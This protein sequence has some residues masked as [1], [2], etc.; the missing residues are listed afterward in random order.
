MYRAQSKMKCEALVKKLSRVPGQRQQNIKPSSWVGWWYGGYKQLLK[1][2]L[3]LLLVAKHQVPG[4]PGHRELY[5]H[6]LF[7][8]AITKCS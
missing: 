7:S 8:K 4:S 1:S 6:P 3:P 2:A 5:T